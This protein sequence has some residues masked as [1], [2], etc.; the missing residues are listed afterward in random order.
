ML[1]FVV[2]KYRVAICVI[3]YNEEQN[4]AQ[5]LQKI[6]D[7]RIIEAHI[8]VD[9]SGSTDRTSDL[10]NKIERCYPDKITHI[11]DSQRVGKHIAYNRLL[12]KVSSYKYSIFVDAD[13]NIEEKTISSLLDYLISHPEH[14]I[15]GPMVLPEIVLGKGLGIKITSIYRKV[16]Q[17]IAISGRYRYLTCKVFVAETR[18]LPVIPESIYAD[19]FYFNLQFKAGEIGVCLKSKIYYVMPYSF[20]GM[21]KHSFHIGNSMSDIKHN[22]KE[23]WKEQLKRIPLSDYVMFGLT[24]NGFED[25]W[26]Q[27]SLVNKLVFFYTRLVTIIGFYVGYFAKPSTRLR[28]PLTETKRSFMERD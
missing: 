20:R 14:K 12:K 15:V 27:L 2:R 22:Y 7:D 1:E 11:R 18:N 19:E 25:F 28:E 17:H 5:L 23:L 16:R 4:V 26:K 21:Y 13:I 3:A 10:I 9:S 6:I 24:K 8:Y